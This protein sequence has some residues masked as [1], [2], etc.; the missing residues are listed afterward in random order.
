M[1]P[2]N[3]SET[4]QP[5][6][7][8]PQ[9]NRPANFIDTAATIEQLQTV[10]LSGIPVPSEA[11]EELRHILLGSP[12]AV[13]QTIHLLHH[14]R[15]V[16]TLRWTPLIAIPQKRLILSPKDGDVMSMLVKHLRLNDAP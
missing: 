16:E 13:R 14:L 4:D 7:N 8:Q 2:T 12:A 3:L 10:E 15:Y 5:K 1:S 6:T 9:P 11:G